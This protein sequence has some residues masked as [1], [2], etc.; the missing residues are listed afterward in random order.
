MPRKPKQPCAYP[1]CPK[2]SDGRYCEEH[3]KVVARTYETYT[4]DPAV[5]KKYGS[6]WKCI[7]DRYVKEHPFCER[8]LKEGRLTSVQEVHHIIPV[9][10][11]GTHDEANLMSLC[12][13]CHNKIHFELGDRNH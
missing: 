6:K 12:R 11:G 3:R 4:R 1:G 9:A 10:S 13:S 5:K 2:L 7:R 8:C